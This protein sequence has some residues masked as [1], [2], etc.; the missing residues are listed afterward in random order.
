MG[1]TSR[2]TPRPVHPPTGDRRLT[3]AVASIAGPVVA[4]AVAAAVSALSAL[5]AAAEPLTDGLKGRTPTYV[6]GYNNQGGLGNGTVARAVRPLPVATPAGTTRLAAGVGFTLALTRSGALYAW[7]DGRWGQL[8]NGTARSRMTAD[9]VEIPG[10]RK[11]VAVDAA[12]DH[13]VA[14]TSDGRV[15]GWGRNDVGQV[16]DGTT[17]DRR[18]PVAVKLPR[19]TRVDAVA[20]GTRHSLAVTT[21]GELL[22]W[23]ANGQG[24][25]GSARGANQ[26]VPALVDVPG[27]SRAAAVT[28]GDAHSVVLTRSGSVFTFG[29][30][31]GTAAAGRARTA[32]HVLRTTAVPGTVVAID[33]GTRHTVALTS[34]GR[35]YAWGDNSSGQLGDST[36]TDRDDPVRV[37]S[38][39][40]VARFASGGSHGVAVERSGRVWAWGDN[41]HGQVGDSST[42]M[43]RTPVQLTALTGATVSAVAAGEFHTAAIVTSGPVVRLKVN[44]AKATVKPQQKQQYV[45]TGLDAFGTA[46]GD[47][48]KKTTLT[49]KG[50]S[51]RGASCWASTPGDHAVTAAV[52]ASKGSAT[53]TVRG[54]RPSSGPTTDPTKTPKPSEN[55]SAGGGRG[56]GGGARAGGTPGGSGANA[57]VSGPG[58][59]LATTGVPAG[60]VLVALLGLAAVV[61]GSV[62][63]ARR[64]ASTGTTS[65]RDDRS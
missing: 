27:R 16:G 39:G 37:R 19:G 21:G 31:A 58:G 23:G 35:L 24:Q 18:T 3:A 48:T 22:A 57:S 50:G 25:L 62:V 60:T 56:P 61:T 42:A 28:A 43:R 11:V 40:A 44:P 13:A 5:P 45:I 1:S 49:I 64:S 46:S 32:P 17:T 55:G 6:W 59:W 14:V 12:G 8:G 36:V 47:L 33:S 20:A 29:V 7:G 15:W 54:T 52:G 53:L 10:G 34:N 9:R 41:T 30:P 4:V 63:L 38:V 26:P 65:K 2:L 51:C